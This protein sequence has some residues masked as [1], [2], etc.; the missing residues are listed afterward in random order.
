MSD[1]TLYLPAF[2]LKTAQE[3]GCVCLFAC[4]VHA[5]IVHACVRMCVHTYLHVCMCICVYVRKVCVCDTVN[6]CVT[7][8]EL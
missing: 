7:L 2:E 1:A 3:V 6:M 4:V 8:L 5:C